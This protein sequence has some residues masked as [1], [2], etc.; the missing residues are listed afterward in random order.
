VAGRYDFVVTADDGVRLYI[1]GQLVLDRWVDQA[2]TTYTVTRTLSSGTHRI[3]MEYYENGGGA[4]AQMSFRLASSAGSSASGCNQGG[5]NF[6]I[7]CYYNSSNLSNLMLIQNTPSI[8]FD[9]GNGSPDSAVRSDGFSAR[10]RGDFSFSGGQYDFVVT[11]DDGV[12]LYIDGQLVL[13]RWVD[14]APTTYRVTRTL[15]SGTHQIVMEYYENGG[16]AVARL[17]W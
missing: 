7:G 14:Q 8:N 9:W 15:S 1:D 11:A 12:R 5:N 3:V 16:G 17:S 4:V 6:F 13:D 10:W 2:P